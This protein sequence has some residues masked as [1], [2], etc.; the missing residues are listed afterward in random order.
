MVHREKDVREPMCM[1]VR[2]L[3]GN[4]VN[5]LTWEKERALHFPFWRF[6]TN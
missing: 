6:Q 5:N 3:I 1:M 4:I 2:G